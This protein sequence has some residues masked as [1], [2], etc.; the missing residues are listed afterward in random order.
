[1][2]LYKGYFLFELRIKKKKTATHHSWH[3]SYCDW[4]IAG[5]EV[6]EFD[7]AWK[8][9]EI[10][11]LADAR[12]EAESKIYFECVEIYKKIQEMFPGE[13]QGKTEERISQLYQRKYAIG[14][15]LAKGPTP[16]K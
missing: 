1:M 15:A 16:E 4:E 7:L 13:T 14:A 12:K 9:A 2:I 10:D 6:S 3:G 11:K 5:I 8:L